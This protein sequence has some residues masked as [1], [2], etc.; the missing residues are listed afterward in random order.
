MEPEVAV[1]AVYGE[2]TRVAAACADNEA[3][4]YL[5]LR[6]AELGAGQPFGASPADVDWRR[7]AR[8]IAPH[9]PRSAR[10]ATIAARAIGS[11][12][13]ARAAASLDPTY[14]ASQVALAAAQTRAGDATAALA[15]LQAV[16][17]LEAVS[18]GLVVLARARLDSGDTKGA[19][20]AAKRG[21]HDRGLAS[22]EPDANDPRPVAEAHAVLGL[23][24][25]RLGKRRDAAREL[26]AAGSLS[27]TARDAIT[28]ADPQLRRELARIHP[29]AR[30]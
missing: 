20:Q 5:R 27:D 30:R 26:T 11:V 17:N 25:L 21:L 29:A 13:A 14:A 19:M 3:I 28:R 4:A 12:E 2:A 9:F 6:T 7:M 16:A 23:T 24:Y 8:E 22:V 1:G 15:T 10:L 18:D